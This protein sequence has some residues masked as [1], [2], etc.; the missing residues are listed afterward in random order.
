MG[1]TYL[2]VI[3]S[4]FGEEEFTTAEF[5]AVTGNFRS[6]K[7]LSELKMRGVVERIGRGEY[8]VLPLSKRPDTRIIE[9][10]RVRNIITKAPWDKAWAGSTAVEIWTNGRYKIS[11]NPYLRV[12]HLLVHKSEV[13]EWK[14]YLR[15]SGISYS[16]KKR[17]GSFVNLEVTSKINST[18]VAGEPVIPKDE[19]LRIIKNHPG[20]YADAGELIEY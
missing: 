18:L 15:K 2:D 14:K 6:A 5:R 9:W 19:V 13:E 4:L 12:F 10:E 1:L 20:L 17:V 7:L 11:P 3:I 8:R 16:G